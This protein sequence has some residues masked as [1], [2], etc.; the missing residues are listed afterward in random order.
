MSQLV[1]IVNVGQHR[2]AVIVSTDF[3]HEFDGAMVIRK[4]T[5]MPGALP[6]LNVSSA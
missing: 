5:S 3:D 4:Y 1:A 2:D 6:R